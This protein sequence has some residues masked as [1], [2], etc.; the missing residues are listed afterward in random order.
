MSDGSAI[1][2]RAYRDC[3]GEFATG[4][5]VVIAEHDGEAA[6]MTLNSFASVSLDPLL[7]LV[8]LGH[9]SRTLYA[10][11]A[12]GRFTIS[13][14][15]RE[16]REVAIDFATAGAPFPRRHV[17]RAYAGFMVVAGAAATLQCILRQ[18][19]R[20][21]DHDLVLGIVVGITHHGGEP[22]IFHRGRFGGLVADAAVPPGHPIA[23]V[24]GAGW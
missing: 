8:S 7:V 3:A 24:E 6:G 15:G 1:P 11:Q 4:V 16:Q 9:G 21:G 2:P 17:T 22:L 20:A 14:L 5:T 23:L 12:S 10:V 13:V 18:V 19:V